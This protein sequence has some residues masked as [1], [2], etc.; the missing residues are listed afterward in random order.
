LYEKWVIAIDV[1][2]AVQYLRKIEG[3]PESI[4]ANVVLGHDCPCF[5]SLF[6][7]LR[8]FAMRQR[9]FVNLCSDLENELWIRLQ[10]AILTALSHDTVF[11]KGLLELEE[12]FAQLAD[13]YLR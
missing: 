5:V 3:Q 7:I 12:I 4:Y 6:I 9:A 13:Q 11:L 1:M 2:R 8:N 10:S